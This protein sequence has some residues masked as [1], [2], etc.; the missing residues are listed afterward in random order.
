MSAT[1]ATQTKHAHLSRT[2]NPRCD[3]NSRNN[4][5]ATATRNGIYACLLAQRRRCGY[6]DSAFPSSMQSFCLFSWIWSFFNT[7]GHEKK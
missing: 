2:T 5:P 3:I 7:T 4:D 6:S 1:T